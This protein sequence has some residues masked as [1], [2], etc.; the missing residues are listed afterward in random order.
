MKLVLQKLLY[1]A[2]MLCLISL[3]S[4]GAIHL[5]PNS[6][7]ASGDL[8]PNITP[9][10]LEQLKRVYGLDQ[11]LWMQFFSWFK[12]IIQLDFGISFASGKLVREEILERLPITLSMNMI[13]MLF[14][15][16]LA[17]YWGIKSAMK[18]K[19][20]YDKTIKQFALLSYAMPSFYLALLLVI[21][22][23]VEWK[24]FPISGL[25]SQG[26]NYVGWRY[27]LD[28]AWHLVLPIFVMIFG[29]L[30]SLILYVRSLT[31]NILKSDYIF[32]ARSRG[33]EGRALLIRFILPNL[34]PPIVTML[35]LSLP[36]LI[37]GS[38]ILESIFAIN[39][40]GLLFYQSALSRDYPVIMGILIIS[41][42]LTLLGNIIADFVLTKLN[43]HF[44]R[45]TL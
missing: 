4:F 44:K 29:G 10:A 6:F 32:F 42:F 39:G 17:L 36:G 7:F 41:S 35:G 28:V 31:L 24:I 25:H 3:I 9:E 13:S 21:S 22:F 12:A 37:G 19:S 33:I 11:S 45:R 2:L 30:G 5:A 38:V 18:S 27:V 14:V 20:L 40:M 15:F 8:N 26:M 23:A 43:P 16:V 34:S 1:V